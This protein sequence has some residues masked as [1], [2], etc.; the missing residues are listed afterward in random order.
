M[1]PKNLFKNARFLDLSILLY[2]KN[3]RFWEIDHLPTLGEMVGSQLLGRVCKT[4]LRL[5]L[6]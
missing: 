3:N 4:S 1:T 5:C 6:E 2:S